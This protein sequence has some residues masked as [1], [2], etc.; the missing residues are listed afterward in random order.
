MSSLLFKDIAVVGEDYAVREGMNLLVEEGRIA[1]IG[2]A[3]PHG[4]SGEIYNGRGKVAMPGF[5]NTHSH[6]PMTL[7]RGYGEGLPLHEW[8]FD[9]MIPFEALLSD[10][11]C[12]WGSLLG[13][14]EML[15]SGIVSFTD[16]Y[17]H[18]PGIVRAVM[19]SGI[20]ANLSHGY[21]THHADVRFSD[22]PAYA[23]TL[24]LMEAAK[25]YPGG[26]LIADAS[27]HAEYTFGEGEIATEIADFCEKSGLRM[28]VHV[29]E[30]KQEHE[31]CRGRR[32][33]TPIQFFDKHGLFRVPTTAAHCVWMDE[34]DFD[35]L[36]SRGVTVAH[37]P[38]SNMKLGSGVAPIAKMLERG[39]KVSIGT[40]GA[41]S[42]NN[43]NGLEEVNLAAM[44]Q[45]GT[46]GNPLFLGPSQLLELACRNGALSQ[47]R[48]DCGA[49]A[50][51]N[52]AD[53]VVYDL[54]SAHLQPV[55]DVLSNLLFA[56][57][58]S[59]IALTMVDGRVLY[60]DGEYTTID[61]K[62][63]IAEAKR[64]RGEK[65]ALLSAK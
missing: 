43:L 17:M 34:A 28:Q 32:G 47:G 10:E 37:C 26:R 24:F 23:G 22:S 42:N 27:V 62:R 63:V 35:I 49:I 5:F 52:R 51:G 25:E 14:A 40:D 57:Q 1:H 9:R 59:D 6:V 48:A 58:A 39:V 54:E 4:F 20:K 13:I 41:A 29:S 55:F 64:I 44:V 45:K 38:S 30:T 11:D 18:T 16:M 61:I 53:I 7:L 15:S 3:T 65:L 19:E 56:G 31:A 46:T 21:S 2:P 36:A 50:V 33:M 12:Y 60:K 8:L